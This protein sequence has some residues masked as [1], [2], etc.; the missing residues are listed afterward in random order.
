M[1]V[2]LNET[3]LWYRDI[4]DETISFSSRL[5]QIISITQIHKKIYNRC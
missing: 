4:C 2:I 3:H 1:N 5:R